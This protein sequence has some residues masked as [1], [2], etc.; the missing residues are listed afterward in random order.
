[1]K[2]EGAESSFNTKQKFKP[3]TNLTSSKGSSQLLDHIKDEQFY[4]SLTT[5]AL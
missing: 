5:I 1:M 3:F 2:L 4:S